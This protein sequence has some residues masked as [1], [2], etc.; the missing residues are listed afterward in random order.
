VP[1][2]DVTNA[3]IVL[4][5]SLCLFIDSVVCSFAL[6]FSA[7]SFSDLRV[8]CNFVSSMLLSLISRSQDCAFCVIL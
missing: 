4:T 2:R 5:A 8:V 7:V 1:L 6:F 3:S